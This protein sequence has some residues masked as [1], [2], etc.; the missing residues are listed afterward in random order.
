MKLLR[1]CYLLVAFLF[2]AGLGSARAQT[3]EWARLVRA[4]TDTVQTSSQLS[5]TDAAGN[6]YTYATFRDDLIIDGT[7]LTASAP[8]A[9]VVIKYDA[10]GAVLW[11]KRLQN[12][13]V[14]QLAADNATGGVFL[15]AS[16]QGAGTW[17]GVALATAPNASLYAKCSATGTLQ[18]AQALP[19]I[20]LTGFSVVADD[21]GSA[22][23][24][25][26][27]GV[28]GTVGGTSV[29]DNETFVLKANGAGAPQWVR[30]LHGSGA[31]ANGYVGAVLGPKPGG[32]CVIGGL[33]RNA[34]YLGAG[35]TTLLLTA[36]STSYTGFVSSFDAAGTHQWTALTGYPPTLQDYFAIS[37][38]AA[39][40]SGNCYVTGTSSA[41]FQAGSATQP[42]GYYLAR[43]GAATGAL[44]WT[45]GQ[46]API[47]YNDAGLLLAPGS[48]GVT[49]LVRATNPA[50][51]PL[52]LGP[53]TLRTYYSFVHYNPQG[54]EQWAV[55]DSRSNYSASAPITAYFAPSSMGTDALGNVYA[56]GRA[57]PQQ[58]RFGPT[59]PLTV[60]QLGSQTTVGGGTIVTR[61]NAY[62][63]TLRGQ[64]Y[65]DLN[66]NGQLDAGEGVFPRQLTGLLTQ[67]SATTYVPVGA[68]GLLQA[69]A[70]P[71][72]YTLSLATL[73][74]H[75]LLTQP[76]SGSFTGTFSGTNQLVSGQNFGLVPMANQADV[77]VTLT[78]YGPARPG[79]TTRYRLTVDNVGTTVASG[80]ATLTLDSRMAY[81]SSTPSAS[82]TGQVL[83]WTYA[84]LAPFG[85]LEY[86]VLFSLP[87][88]T[89]AGTVL[90]TA[91]AAPLPADVAPADNTAAL[92]QTVVSSYD[93]NSIE[94]NYE[95]LT[96][97]QVSAQQPLDYTIH[98]QN[99]GTAA[100]ST[101]ILSDTLDFRKLNLASLMLVAQSH[102]CIWSLA[103]AGPEKGLLTVRFLNINLPERNVDVIR[104]MG[105]VRFRVQP[106]A[107]LTVGE[108][109][110]NHA[111]I[112]FDY[113]APVITNIATTTVFQ[114]TAALARHEAPAWTAYPNPATDAISIAADLATAGP[115][116]IELLD[117]L[118][119]PLRRQTLTAPAGPLRQL[120]DLHG[121]AAGV[122]LL[123]LTP[124][125]GPATSRRVVLH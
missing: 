102:S 54:A 115:V 84:S 88:N 37:A 78:P 105:F 42:S 104:S 5:A 19:S 113:N 87:T 32:G 55:A 13:R 107:T 30:V 92:A 26:V 74:A 98:F 44:Q 100:A 96:P 76:G 64:V 85:R 27:M 33:F 18:W 125:T 89:V 122:Y 47:S 39:D 58:P 103:T 112:V 111:G 118:G 57:M 75:Y 109:I 10:T 79:Y 9:G 3:F 56:V 59:G 62:A 71:G 8:G 25:G 22:Y 43:Y 68:D 91:A 36:P 2:V 1:H 12:L 70:E 60:V 29:N 23:V 69:Y 38:V 108:I 46:Q 49:V 31:G 95:R 40:A 66:A 52:I 17:D 83:T 65:A 114:A 123:R 82:R 15:A 93:P 4:A 14:V 99:L 97:A 101:V 110:P 61:I 121:L 48:Q 116:A 86:D 80:T 77:S 41:G 106:R 51:Q 28:A 16:Q 7:T 73:P 24:S 53:L 35:T 50:A 21:A 72:A 63:N 34:L 119:R 117:V 11:F 81:I 90:N 94:V 124:P 67:G 20:Y 45:R 120:V 6:T